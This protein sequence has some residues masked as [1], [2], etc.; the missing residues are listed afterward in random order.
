MK[1]TNN[2]RQRLTL[3]E[4]ATLLHLPPATVYHLALAGVLP[5]ER[6][7]GQVTIKQPRLDSWKRHWA[8]KLK[9]QDDRVR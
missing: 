8:K 1:A 4:T 5:Y 9:S 7:G 6:I 3:Y 2:A